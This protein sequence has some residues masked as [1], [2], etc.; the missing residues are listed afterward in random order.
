MRK[1]I[2][3]KSHEAISANLKYRG[4]EVLEENWA[5]GSDGIDF[6]VMD[7][8]ELIFVDTATKCGGYDIES[9]LMTGSEKAFYATTK[10][11][12]RREITSKQLPRTFGLEARHSYRLTL[13]L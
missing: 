4:I 3:E 1:S 10:R 6:I 5:H 13:S 2:D 8:E 12:Q 11:P 7:D 9:L